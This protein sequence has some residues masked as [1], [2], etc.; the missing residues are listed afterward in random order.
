MWVEGLI[1]AWLKALKAHLRYLI[2]LELLEPRVCDKRSMLYFP[3]CTQCTRPSITKDQQSR[4]ALLK[5]G[6]QLSWSQI[7]T[8]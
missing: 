2:F 6:N 4:L 5:I 1:L 8:G 7:L 3:S